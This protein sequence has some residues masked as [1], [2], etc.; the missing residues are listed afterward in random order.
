MFKQIMVPV[1]LGHVDQLEK[2][3]RIA[4][5]ISKL[6]GAPVCYVGVANEQ[7]SSVSHDPAEYDRKLGK[8][9]EQ[10]VSLY[11]HKVSSRT[12]VGHDLVTDIDDVLLAAV[13]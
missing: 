4:A 9:A 7:P 6:Y 3:L 12:F 13:K 11:G 1:D 5:D 10:Q 2:S 8:F